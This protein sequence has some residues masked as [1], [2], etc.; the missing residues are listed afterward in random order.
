MSKTILAII[1]ARSGSKGIPGKNMID[2]CGR[3][4]IDY[5]IQTIHDSKKIS[6]AIVSTDSKIIG[7]YCLERGVDFPFIRPNH[8]SDDKAKSIDVVIHALNCYKL[9]GENYDYILL[10]QPTTPF[11]N[12]NWVD[13]AIEQLEA[14]NNNCLISVK[15]VPHEYNPNWQFQISESAN[16][17][18]SYEK[19]IIS[20]RQELNS[21]FVR[22]GGIYLV[23]VEYL[24]ETK[25]FFDRQMDY[26]VN[27]DHPSI[28]IDTL[29]D[30]NLARNYVEKD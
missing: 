17:I 30:L 26:I 18:T 20:R 23:R 22:D 24:L 28:N 8:L 9:R 5:T 16:T 21:T 25:S 7:D 29:S 14:S 6:K 1:P 3:P 2:L 15:P 27:K 13:M 11:R 10:L 12:G 4:L 19:D